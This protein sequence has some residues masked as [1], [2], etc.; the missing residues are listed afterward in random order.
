LTGSTGFRQPKVRQPQVEGIEG[1]TFAARFRTW[2]PFLALAITLLGAFLRLYRIDSLPPG[3]TYDPAFY[4]LDALAILRGERPIF[5]ETNFGREPL[6]SYLVA[7]WV[8]ILGVGSQAIHVA[9]AAVGILTIPAVYL[10]AEE[11]FADET[12]LLGQV[13]GLAAALALALSFWHLGWS[14]YGVRA[15]LVPLF[16]AMT[17][18][19]SWR[20]IRT[21]SRW[22]FAACGLFLGLSMY[23]YQ[24][25][26]LL[27]LLVFLG[28]AYAAWR[29]KAFS[30]RDGMNLIL[31]SAIALIVFAPLGY[32]A[33]LHFDRFSERVE[34]VSVLSGSEKGALSILGKEWVKTLLVFSF[35]GDEK[36]TINLPGRPALNPFLSFA[37]AAGIAIALLRIKRPSYFLLLAWLGVMSVPGVLAGHGPT[38]KRII[39]TLPAVTML[40]AVGALVPLDAVCRWARRRPSLGRRALTVALALVLASGLVYSGAR[41]YR[42]YFV[43]WGEDPAL[44]THFEAGLAAI[45]QYIGKRPPEER[46]YVSPVYVGHPSILYNSRERPG[47]KGYHGKFCIVLPDGA[48]HDTTYVIVPG[49]DK[50]SLNLLSAYLP[51][52]EITDAGPLHYQQPYFLAYHVPAGAQPRIDPAHKV[53]ANWDDKI[54]LLGCD[55]DPLAPQ[56]GE[57]IQVTLYSHA[58]AEMETD[59]TVFVQLVGPPNPATDGLLWSQDDSEPCRRYRPTSSWDVEEVLIDT[60]A[61]S[62]PAQAP[63]G[64]Y[65]LIVGFYDWRTFERLPVLDATGQVSGDHVSLTPIRVVERE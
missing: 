20:G 35:R 57:K 29:R 40:I 63:E 52:G 50:R 53:Q 14:R 12:G 10:V 39:G 32:Y 15:I 36:P 23:T 7:A 58:L 31:L 2:K 11:V 28:V 3:E 27:P 61:L 49:E 46:I 30:K 24:A 47:V 6:F 64:E 1:H 56:A 8:A 18:Y 60:F 21:Q 5:L 44:F 9:S 45:G 55:V 51:Q 38:A 62:I 65:E 48:A 26:R 33:I 37:F 16:A 59:Y 43:A 4:G 13:G 19:L 17:T 22:T 25:A 41:T 34:Q 54:Q 42:D